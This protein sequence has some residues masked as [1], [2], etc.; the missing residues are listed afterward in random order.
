MDFLKLFCQSRDMGD[1]LEQ[2]RARLFRM[3]YA[4]CHNRALADDLV[5]ET[6]TKAMQ[7][8]SQLR[9][10]KAR[11]AWL[12]SIL[13]NC[14]RDHFR[15]QREMED[16]DEIDVPHDETPETENSQLEI[17]RK[18]RAAVTRLPEGQ[19]Q[20]IT[21]VDLEGFSYV[22]VARVLDIPIGTVMSRLCRA[23]DALLRLLSTEFGNPEV[24]RRAGLR[25]VK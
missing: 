1:A 17:V 6:L 4:W 3:A 13:T 9:D 2:S 19:R 11:D 25:R 7:K 8:S 20:V 21:L 23:R 12:F 16:I 22:E 15:R 18:V 10:P 14:F 5:Q 24:L